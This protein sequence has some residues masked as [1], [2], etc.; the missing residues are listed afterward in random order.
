M[1]ATAAEAERPP[2][3]NGEQLGLFG[4]VNLKHKLVY[5]QDHRQHAIAIGVGFLRSRFVVLTDDA[6][7]VSAFHEHESLACLG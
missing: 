5:R 4:D 3:K 6:F 2:A 7:D 1:M